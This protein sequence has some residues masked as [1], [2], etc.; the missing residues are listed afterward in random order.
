MSKLP[1]P[2]FSMPIN[3]GGDAGG[4]LQSLHREVTEY[5][6]K[7]ERQVNA[8]SESRVEAAYNAL[9]AAPTGVIM[10]NGDVVL[11]SNPT[12]AG[13]AGAKYVITGWMAIVDGTASAS[14]VVELR[15]LT[16]N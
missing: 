9:T 5:M 2:R 1:P 13:T 12:E 14:S 11:K 3:V 16:G 8:L 7:V 15:S 4:Y 10:A 6:G